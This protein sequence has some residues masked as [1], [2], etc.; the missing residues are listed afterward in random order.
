MKRWNLVLYAHT[1]AE[2]NTNWNSLQDD[3]NAEITTYLSNTWV[4]PW[5]RRFVKCFTD[6]HLHLGNVTTSRNESSNWRLKQGL[7]TSTGDLTAVSENITQLLRRERL[8]WSEDINAAKACIRINQRAPFFRDVLTE[9]PPWI[10]QKVLGQHAKIGDNMPVCTSSYTSHLGIPCSHRIKA[11]LATAPGLLQVEDFHLHWRYNKPASYS[12]RYALR[13]NDE[14]SENANTDPLLRVQEPVVG[15]E[16][17]RPRGSAAEPSGKR[18]RR[19]EE[20]DRSTRREPSAFERVEQCLQARAPPTPPPACSPHGRGGQRSRAGRTAT[21]RSGAAGG[22]A[23]SLAITASQVAREEEDAAI[24]AWEA[25]LQERNAASHAA[26]P[27]SFSVG[28]LTGSPAGCS[29]SRAE[30][31]TTWTRGGLL[32]L[33]PRRPGRRQPSGL[34]TIRFLA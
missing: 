11:R 26:L 15:R 6:R 34:S 8:K 25:G 29:R 20:F 16:K 10:L 4:F 2:F 12:I 24:N 21:P 32:S 9:I 22:V 7:S 33:P 14:E 3:Y 31:I 18:T 1:E 17:G 30:F 27:A 5:K 19:Q 23:P 13:E 28:T